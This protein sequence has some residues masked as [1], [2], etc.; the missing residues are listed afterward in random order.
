MLLSEES[1]KNRKSA[2]RVRE[3]GWE[4]TFIYAKVGLMRRMDQKTFTSLVRIDC[5]MC[6]SKNELVS[7]VYTA[8]IWNS[9]KM[10]ANYY[11]S[12]L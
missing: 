1:C 8:N 11:L 4:I 2:D 5:T 12:K 10:H 7:L 3:D 9:G 6:K